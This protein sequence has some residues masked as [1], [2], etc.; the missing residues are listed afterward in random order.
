M[1]CKNTLPETLNTRLEKAHR[2]L[3]KIVA[4]MARV[5]AGHHVEVRQW[6]AE[7]IARERRVDERI[8][9]LVIAIGELIRNGKR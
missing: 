2:K 9:K 5:Q 4:D 1:L 7:A 6:Q 8:E 3:A